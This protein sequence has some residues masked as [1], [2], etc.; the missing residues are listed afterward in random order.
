MNINESA[1][2]GRFF[3]DPTELASHLRND[4]FV[5]DLFDND[6]D[7]SG[8]RKRRKIDV[9]ETICYLSNKSDIT[10]MQSM[11]S[12][13][14]RKLQQHCDSLYDDYKT[15]LG[16]ENKTVI[17]KKN[18]VLRFVMNK[19]NTEQR[20]IFE[21]IICLLGKRH[22]TR[23]LNNYSEPVIMLLD[24]NPGVGKTFLI[25]ALG[26]CLNKPP[27]YT[28]YT[29]CL[30]SI[31]SDV[32][33]MKCYTVCSMFMQL[34]KMKYIEIKAVFHERTRS[35]MDMLRYY[36]EIV[37]NELNHEF[38]LKEI[39][40]CEGN[41]EFVKIDLLVIEEYLSLSPWTIVMLYLISVVHDIN[42]LFV[43][44]RIQ[45]SS[46]TKSR[47]H[48]KNNYCLVQTILNEE[49]N[50]FK[51]YKSVRQENDKQFIT[52]IKMFKNTIS[53]TS[54]HS[55]VRTYFCFKYLLFQMFKQ[56]FVTQ[57]SLTSVYLAQYH[58]LLKAHVQFKQRT[59]TADCMQAYIHIVERHGTTIKTPKY[60]D[61]LF[62]KN[63]FLPYIYLFVGGI[64]L[65][66]DPVTKENNVVT[67]VRIE[68]D[69][70]TLFVK[71]QNSD[72]EILVSRKPIAVSFMHEELVKFLR[73]NFKSCSIYQ[74]PLRDVSMTYCYVQGLTLSNVNVTLNIDTTYT[75]SVYV[76]LTRVQ[77]EK[78]LDHL[79][80]VELNNLIV[81]D[82]MDD[83]FY[84]KINI[85]NVT[86]ELK[87][88][89]IL[90]KEAKLNE[91]STNNVHVK[92]LLKK[93]T[94][95]K[96]KVIKTFE[97]THNKHIKILKS[98]FIQHCKSISDNNNEI[99]ELQTLL[100]CLKSNHHTIL[101]RN[102]NKT[103]KCVENN[104]L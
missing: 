40:N 68:N 28:V 92:S 102:V 11:N 56:K 13:S 8:G 38:F 85:E 87:T 51:L 90:W 29:N 62:S 48:K 10:I 9:F 35:I 78:Q 80:T 41:K 33:N 21:N 55:S 17:G 53:G 3:T 59:C 32:L 81:T 30:A 61:K 83:E 12:N 103:M 76:G 88:A 2:P 52:K 97:C 72:K 86:D 84:Y 31:M 89:L 45:Q 19:L 73:S 69:G 66:T 16:E 99:S 75:N 4:A 93:L 14:L 34:L 77:M 23:S 96:T 44:D 49:N 42:L 104:I 18:T 95:S 65:M 39:V 37:Y 64:Y 27:I 70:N 46:S 60:L 43:G 67:L 58:R 57:K 7:E 1:E 6:T 25:A 54:E 71:T 94:F 47:Y 5:L 79:E 20:I 26:A 74:F 98:I 101:E 50:S 82:I 91:G 22:C 100:I 36:L 24:S 15:I 63:K